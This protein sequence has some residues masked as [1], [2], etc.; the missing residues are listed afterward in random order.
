[1][2]S[3]TQRPTAKIYQFPTEASRKTSRFLESD[4]GKSGFRQVADLPA[5]STG[6]WY[7]EVA[8]VEQERL[9]KR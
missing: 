2:A 1:M 6:A 9:P 8:I 4:G 5:V 3:S 7:H